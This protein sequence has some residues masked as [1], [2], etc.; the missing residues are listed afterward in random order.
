MSRT[1][2]RIPFRD[3]SSR[4][5]AAGL[6]D[7]AG[8]PRPAM[9]RLPVGRGLLRVAGAGV[10]TCVAN[11]AVAEGGRILPPFDLQSAFGSAVIIGLL[12]FSTTLSIQS[13]RDRRRR[14]E[15]EAEL[16]RKT[17]QLKDV[18]DR[19]TVL[20]GSERQILVRWNGGE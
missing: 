7:A 1:I 18:E 6:P 13:V 15:I 3:P 2:T 19:A 11:A 5:V 16:A 14:D 17:A 4:R 12:V 20:L 10:A 9:G 8:G